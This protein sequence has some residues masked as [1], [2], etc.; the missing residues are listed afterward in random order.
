MRAPGRHLSAAAAQ[1]VLVGE[2]DD[3][4]ENENPVCELEE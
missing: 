1:L 4:E 2:D 3:L